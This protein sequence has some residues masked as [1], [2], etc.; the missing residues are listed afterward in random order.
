MAT[1]DLQARR[2]ETWSGLR[3]HVARGMP[4]TCIALLLASISLLLAP[5]SVAQTAPQGLPP[6]V[7]IA[8]VQS[9]E[10]APPAETATRTVNALRLTKTLVPEPRVRP[11]RAQGN[12]LQPLLDLDLMHSDRFCAVA[13][14]D[15]LC[16][17][18][19]TG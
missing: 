6:A 13:P 1:H 14:Q 8:V 5:T 19:A 9:R 18:L 7:T 2:F 16:Q 11:K 12:I 17:F 4:W 10:V 15:L 3:G